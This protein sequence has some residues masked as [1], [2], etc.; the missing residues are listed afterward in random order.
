VENYRVCADTTQNYILGD[1]YTCC[2][3]RG[4]A[5]IDTYF[6]ILGADFVLMMGLT[7]DAIKCTIQFNLPCARLWSS[8]SVCNARGIDIENYANF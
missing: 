7:Q 8:E 5:H 3:A 4:P 6:A 2:C 1:K